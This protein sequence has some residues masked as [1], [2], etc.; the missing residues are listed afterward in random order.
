M[1]TSRNGKIA[2]LPETLR[3]QL[4]HRLADA[5]PGE[6]LLAWLNALPEVQAILASQFNG[7]PISKQNLSEWRAGGFLA[8]QI[9][10]EFLGQAQD[11]AMDATELAQATTD[12]DG[13]RLIDHLATVLAGRYASLLNH[14]D[15]E[16]TQPF[17]QKLR[18]LTSLCRA[19]TQLRRGDNA[20]RQPGVATAGRPTPVVPAPDPA[21]PSSLSPLPSPIPSDSVKPSQTN[22]TPS[23][24]STL[25][26]QGLDNARAC[27]RPSVTAAGRTTP[28]QP[29][30]APALPSSLYP[31]PSPVPS[32]SVKPS[33]TNAAAPA[34]G[35]PA[36]AASVQP[37]PILPSP[38]YLKPTA[39][40][41]IIP[42][43]PPQV[44]IPRLDDLPFA[45]TLAH[46]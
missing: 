16:I 36:S 46:L 27:Q 21:L 14:W 17:T 43:L 28:A 31:L 20:R 13:T 4:N 18:A 11:L 39:G 44:I 42:G 26:P 1:S 23:L 5:E 22:P 24:P 35:R 41:P 33:Q 38:K 15:G 9:H 2:R 10:A 45:A 34:P 7:N 6:T 25:C 32:D 37:A 12:E 8:W 40:A 19:I 3:T 30:P 29:T